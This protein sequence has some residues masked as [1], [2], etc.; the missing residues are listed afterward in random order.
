MT[1]PPRDLPRRQLLGS[2]LGG[3]GALTM[4][5]AGCGPS[6]PPPQVV[7]PPPPPPQPDRHVVA[8]TDL[9]T[10][11]RLQWLVLARP[12][13]LM[14]L[15]W[16]R[17]SLARV[18][19]DDR[20]DLLAR[21]TGIDLR[22]APELVLA[23]Y[24]AGRDAPAEQRNTIAYFVRHRRPQLD[25]ERKFRE[26][27]TSRA[28][29]RVGGHQ[30]VS[31]D[32]NIGLTHHSFVAIGPDV[33]GF[34]YGGDARRGPARIALLY[35]EGE[36]DT[37]P[38][39]LDDPALRG[40]HD[41]MGA[42]PLLALLPGPFE[43]RMARGARG[44]LGAASGLSAGLEPTSRQTLRLHVQLAGAFAADGPEAT[45]YLQGA[46]EDLAKSDLGHLLGLHEPLSPPAVA[47]SEH[48]LSLAVELDAGRLLAG[49]A[50]ATVDD[51]QQI[52]KQD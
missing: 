4:A 24:R 19:R 30:L 20:L 49:L 25:I 50:A 9:L 33:A 6:A 31:V 10:I 43:G 3:V 23:S 17:P 40:L 34:Q 27:L 41:R 52:M 48:G 28:T 46:W 22:A 29:R 1:A 16:L 15:D 2:L 11:A 14:A 45:A 44:L 7:T 32:G 8:I 5:A 26:R 42:P 36:L 39:V 38:R 12:E 21:A 37:I 51:I 18:L 13:Q 35:A 47:V